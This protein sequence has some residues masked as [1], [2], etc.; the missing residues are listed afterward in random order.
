MQSYR[1]LVQAV[2]FDVGGTLIEPWPSVGHVY[3]EVAARHGHKNLAP[4]HL[5]RRFAA[6]WRAKENFDHSCAAWRMLVEQ[7]FAGLTASVPRAPLFDDLFQR[8]AEAAAW[9]V[10]EDV[11]PALEW[12]QERQIRL[13]IISNWDERLR[14]LLQ[15]LQLSHY[16]PVKVISI[17]AG[18]PKPHAQI[19]RQAAT[20]LGLPPGSI[21]HVGDSPAEDLAGARA[22]GM[23][24]LLLDR[25]A[26]SGNKP[27][28]ATLADVVRLMEHPGAP[29]LSDKD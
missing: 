12:F 1:M 5:N 7:T 15:Q 17:E 10:Y 6:A 9:R 3:A 4:D 20:E 14:P 2:T 24:G 16:F 19:F 25:A 11:R 22:V 29:E 21:L 13:G 8:F 28:A 23:R 26:R 18:C 27:G